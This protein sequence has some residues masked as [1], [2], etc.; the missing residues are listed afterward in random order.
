MVKLRN[1]RDLI[2][3]LRIKLKMFGVPIDGPADMT[4]DNQGEA[5]KDTS[6]LESMLNKHHNVIT[7]H[8]IRGTDATRM[9]RDAIAID[10]ISLLMDAGSRRVRSAPCWYLLVG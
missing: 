6:L 2:D 5:V 4:C 3:L 7:Y 10:I 9:M 8:A 1:A